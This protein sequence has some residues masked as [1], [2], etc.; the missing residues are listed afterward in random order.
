M[1]STMKK[2]RLFSLL[3]I[4]SLFIGLT[5]CGSV[6]V[7]GQGH[8]L[9]PQ[10]HGQGGD[11]PPPQ[12]M[13]A[14][15]GQTEV[16][17]L[18]QRSTLDGILPALV[19]KRVVYV[20]ETHDNYAHHLNQ[21]EVI[22]GIHQANPKVAIGL[23][24]F[25]RPFQQTLDAFI[26]GDLDEGEFLK[27]SEWFD[28]WRYDYRLYQPIL[29]YAREQGLPLVAL[30][31]STEIRERVS[32]VGFAGLNPAE[33]AQVPTEIDRSDTI[34]VERLRE[35]FQQHAGSSKRNFDHFLDVQ[36]LWDETMAETAA[37]FLQQHPATSLVVLAG[38]GHLMYGA[39]IPR[40]VERR[41]GQAGA[42][43][44]P[45]SNLK[46]EPGI[47]DFILFPAPQALP[48]AG[49]MGIFMESAEG[50]VAVA[51]LSSGST[52]AAA[53]VKKG[54]LIIGL[55]GKPVAEPSDIKVELMGQPPGA[56][57]QLKVLRKKVL[58]GEEQLD[59]AFQ[60]GG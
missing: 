39:G 41:L 46:V 33:A 58:W 32:A 1:G 27:Q 22:K 40:R 53:G 25:Q 19:K 59:F 12:T 28:R 11:T 4:A 8:M 47:A 50:G 45:G 42:I 18:S 56:S 16:L 36:L 54:D 30:N 60:L 23:E 26:A 51:E 17:D 13:E 57:V 24:M 52:S 21:L 5:A 7:H 29:N 20:G 34:Y 31:A 55:N 35:V 49:L 48:K 43:I 3:L 15:S 38:S 9:P 44:L 14:A 6:G 37:L 10:D 2:T